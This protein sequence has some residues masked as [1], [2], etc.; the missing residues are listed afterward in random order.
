MQCT[1]WDA[2]HG[3]TQ[4]DVKFGTR[5]HEKTTGNLHDHLS[6]W[7]LDFDIN[8]PVNTAHKTVGTEQLLLIICIEEL[9][10]LS[11]TCIL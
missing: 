9:P 8:G 5:V 4:P 1:F 3:I 11:C 10:A 7:K 6:A 2:D